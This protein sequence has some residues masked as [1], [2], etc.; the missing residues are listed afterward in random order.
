M[1]NLRGQAL[2]VLVAALGYFVDIYDLVLFSVVRISSLQDLG[3]SGTDLMDK[4]VFLLNMQ[5]SG[6]LVGGIFWV[7]L[8]G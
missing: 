4:G 3:L 2:L 8:G 6:M 7:C 5:M 1:P